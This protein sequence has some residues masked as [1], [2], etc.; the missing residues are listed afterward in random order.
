MLSATQSSQHAPESVTVMHWSHARNLWLQGYGSPL[1]E[2]ELR[3]MPPSEAVEGA[4]RRFLFSWLCFM[5]YRDAKAEGL[6]DIID[7]MQSIG[8]C[9][10]ATQPIA[11]V[12]EEIG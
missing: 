3:R 9:K 4:R 7:E 11:A 8:M 5:V 12:L 2:P 1:P 6:Y 10:P